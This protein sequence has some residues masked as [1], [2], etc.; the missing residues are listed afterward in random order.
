MAAA[1]ARSS[2]AIQEMF[3]LV[4]RYFTEIFRRKAFLHWYTG[5]GRDE[6]EFTKAESNMVDAKCMVCAA[7]PRHVRHLTAASLFEAACP[8]RKWMSS[9]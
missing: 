4:A 1:F 5:E 2:T 8:R 9:C 7:D 3:K 6:M